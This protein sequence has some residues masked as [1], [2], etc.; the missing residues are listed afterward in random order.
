MFSYDLVI[1]GSVICD[2]LSLFD[3]VILEKNKR[4]ET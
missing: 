4:L 2:K 1:V 3:L